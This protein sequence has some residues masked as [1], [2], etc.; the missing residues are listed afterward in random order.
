MQI[1][2]MVRQF[3]MAPVHG[4]ATA[5]APSRYKPMTIRIALTA[6]EVANAPWVNRPH[7]KPEVGDEPHREKGADLPAPI[8]R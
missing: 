1:V 4:G 3:V 5:S 7:R 8:G 6:I 2:L